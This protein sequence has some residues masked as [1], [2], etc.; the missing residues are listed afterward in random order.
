[1]VAHI[2][3]KKHTRHGIK[4]PLLYNRLPALKPKE[5]VLW[6]I[7]E[8]NFLR[9]WVGTNTPGTIQECG[10]SKEKWGIARQT[11]NSKSVK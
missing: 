2:A 5:Y 7:L 9:M 6:C 3:E 1:M 8:S 4:L 10:T 11:K